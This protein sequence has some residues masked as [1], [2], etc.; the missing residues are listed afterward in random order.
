[1]PNRTALSLLDEYDSSGLDKRLFQQKLHHMGGG[2]ESFYRHSFKVSSFKSL[3]CNQLLIDRVRFILDKIRDG[4][5]RDQSSLE[6]LIGQSFK[7]IP[8]SR[9]T[10]CK[11]HKFD[12]DCKHRS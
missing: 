8:C 3:G 10:Q 1:M 7:E 5:P 9:Y 4:A 2:F 12:P 6:K 11:G